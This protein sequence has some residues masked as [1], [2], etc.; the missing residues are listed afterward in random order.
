MLDTDTSHDLVNI[1]STS[2]YGGHTGLYTQLIAGKSHCYM[3]TTELHLLPV[4]W[5][6][7]F[8]VTLSPCPPTADLQLP[9]HAVQVDSS[10]Y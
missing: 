1:S 2:V 5:K 8:H 7:W 9:S 4:H 10:W 6:Q 3:T